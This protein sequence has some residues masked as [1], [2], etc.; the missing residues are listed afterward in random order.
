MPIEKMTMYQNE[1]LSFG[2]C[3]SNLITIIRNSVTHIGGMCLM[4]LTLGQICGTRNNLSTIQKFLVLL[5]E[6]LL[7]NFQALDQPINLGA[8]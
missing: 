6:E 8:T 1:L 4:S 7:Q 3:T 2:M 5:P